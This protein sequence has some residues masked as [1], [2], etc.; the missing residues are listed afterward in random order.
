M[1]HRAGLWLMVCQVKRVGKG[2]EMMVAKGLQR[3]CKRDAEALQAA[4]GLRLLLVRL[5]L[6]PATTML[7]HLTAHH[8]QYLFP[9]LRPAQKPAPPPR[10]RCFTGGCLGDSSRLR[11][12]A[13][14]KSGIVAVPVVRLISPR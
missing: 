2:G 5:L 6:F 13:E 3:L 7:P 9:Q 4:S 1:N 11:S 12:A 8:R 10:L 14:K